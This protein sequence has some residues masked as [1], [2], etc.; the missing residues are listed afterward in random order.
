MEQEGPGD[1]FV[2]GPFFCAIRDVRRTAL[3]VHQDE[4]QILGFGPVDR[5]QSIPRTA[6]ATTPSSRSAAASSLACRVRAGSSA[7]VPSI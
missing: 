6:A 5:A 2:S 3:R 1:V 7:N 4:A